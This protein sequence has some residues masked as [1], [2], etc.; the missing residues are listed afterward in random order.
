MFQEKTNNIFG[1]RRQNGIGKAYF[2]SEKKVHFCSPV[3]QIV[4]QSDLDK[5]NS[6]GLEK[7]LT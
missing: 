2:Y 3:L 7:Y 5:S 1:V 4:I 6:K